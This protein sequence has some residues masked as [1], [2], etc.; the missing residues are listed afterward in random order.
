MVPIN[1]QEVY[2]EHL[3]KNSLDFIGAADENGDII[4]YN[5]AALRAFGYTLE[6][7]LKLDVR[8]LYS[9]RED[10]ERVVNALNETGKFIGE[11]GNIRKNGEKFTCFLSAN[12]MYDNDGEIVGS[13]G[14]SR[15]ISREKELTKQLEIQNDKNAKLIDELVSLSRIATNVSNGIV[16]TDPEG[17]MKW[18]NDSFSRITGYT[19]N[20]LI[21]YKP[22]ELF[23][24]PHFFRETFKE[25]SEANRV[26]NIPIQVPH[27]HKEGDLYW[28]L[29]ESSPVYDDEGN[30]TEIIEVCT[31][32]TDQKNAEMALTESEANFRQ[33]SETIEDVFFLYNASDK[34]YEYVSPNSLE[35]MGVPPEFFYAGK[36]Y[37][38]RF[39]HKD[40][41][42][43][44]RRG[45]VDLMNGNRYDV[46]YRILIDNE[47]KWLR[48]RAFPVKDE[49]GRIIKGSGV[50][51]DIT[52]FKYDRKLIELQN[53]N[54]RESISYAQHIQKSTL[55]DEADIKL[56]FK[57]SFLYF[58]PK[59]ELSGDFYIADYAITKT[60]RKLPLFVIADCTGHGVPGA[61]LSILCLSLIRQTFGDHKINSPA[62]ALDLVRNQLAKLFYSGDTLQIKDGMDVGLGVIDEK[63][64]QLRYSGANINAFIFR[65]KSWIELK[66]SKQHVGYS[67]KPVPFKN[68]IFDYESGDQLYLFTDGFVDQFGGDHNKKYMKRKLMDFVET[69]A[70]EPMAIQR[71]MIEL[72]FVSWKGDEE[73][74][75]DICCFGLK[76]D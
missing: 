17:R 36:E 31:E 68:I 64:R 30:L 7:L 11:V 16:I 76:F 45:R 10:F 1:R 50:V 75:D 54:I 21:G 22:S 20:E 14:V 49:E 41:R 58:S 35:M 29:V 33:M 3:I 48:E 38:N 60:Q 34:Q 69:I 24:I 18:C 5:P 4:E 70:E 8:E 46:E 44:I 6:E 51:S 53:K 61:I 67:E 72:E 12:I 26:S 47:E 27:Y 63:I 9:S 25:L 74:T 19:S 73:Q 55:Q 2:A 23:R 37:L 52:E 43:L 40:D 59:G 15:D 28:I 66:G 13:M 42:H 71:K 56:V 62:E 39:V 57:N 32:I 65:N